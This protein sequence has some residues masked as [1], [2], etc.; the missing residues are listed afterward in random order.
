MKKRVWQGSLLLLVLF[1]VVIGIRVY[2][3]FGAPEK[4]ESGY[5]SIA[6]FART[7]QLVRQDYVDEK[8]VDYDELTHAALKGMLSSLDPHSQ[9]MEVRDFKGMQDDTN[10][11]FGGLGIVVTMRDSVLTIVSPMEDTP[12]F[13]AGLLPGDQIVKIDGQSTEKMDLNDAIEKLRGEPGQKGTL[14]ILRPSSK[15]IKDYPMV[16]ENIK[17]AS[18]KDARILPPELAGDL[19]IGYA[20]ITQFNS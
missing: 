10:S 15:E 13:R 8:K 11:R 17:V 4:D 20:R 1:N 3:A 19:K 5:G 14:T 18:V 16:R 12:G 9:F 2:H 7:M 6:L